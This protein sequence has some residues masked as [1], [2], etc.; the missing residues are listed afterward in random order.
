MKHKLNLA[1]AITASRMAFAGF[2]L[3]CAVFSAPFYAWYLLGAF[4]D[5][6]DG[7]V[8]RKLNLKSSFGAKLDSIADGVFVI[9]VMAKVLP[10]IRIP[11]WL[12]IWIAMIALIKFINLATSL[13]I[14]HRIVP[15]HT[16]MNKV[17]GFALFLLP[18]GIGRG[19]WQM[20]AIA[21]IAT[22]AT[23][24]LAAIQEGHSIRAGKDIE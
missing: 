13:V 17:T 5:M 11:Q 18:L 16:V 19:A 22:C 15:V 1:D 9:A 12:W 2:L 10:A 23:A 24:T 3:F 6:I 21:V 4:T 20:T 7:T 14:F 8:A